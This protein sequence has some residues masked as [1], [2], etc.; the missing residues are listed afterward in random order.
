MHNIHFINKKSTL[1]ELIMIFQCACCR[2]HHKIKMLN[3]KKEK[4][5]KAQ[6]STYL[7]IAYRVDNITF[8]SFCKPQNSFSA[9]EYQFL[10]LYLH[11]YLLVSL[12]L[13]TRTQLGSL[14]HSIL[15]VEILF[16]IENIYSGEG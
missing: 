3:G 15:F 5:I 2:H 14:K 10:Y 4:K 11:I 13:S 9:S 8:F 7:C 6:I 12:Y 16:C 1:L